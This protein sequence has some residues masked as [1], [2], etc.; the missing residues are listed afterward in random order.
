MLPMKILANF[1]KHGE[2]QPCVRPNM[3]DNIKALPPLQRGHFAYGSNGFTVN[4]IAPVSQ[5]R[6][7]EL[8]FPVQIKE[9]RLQKQRLEDAGK[10]M[11]KPWIQAQLRYYE[12]GF[13]SSCKVG[14]LTMQLTES[15]QHGNVKK[16][17]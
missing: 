14:E 15:V 1:T 11:T 8:V 10:I 7:R 3:S 16:S 2:I 9:K 4:G 13:K 12:I 6:L 17:S 5:S